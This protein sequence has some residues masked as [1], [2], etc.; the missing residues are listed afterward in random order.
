MVHVLQNGLRELTDSK[1]C[2]SDQARPCFNIQSFVLATW[3]PRPIPALDM[4]R[5]LSQGRAYPGLYIP[6]RYQLSERDQCGWV[7]GGQNMIGATRDP[8]VQNQVGGSKGGTP[9]WPTKPRT[10]D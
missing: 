9:E 4:L 8:S 2:R 5:C 6:S 1:V 10:V 7:A 3:V